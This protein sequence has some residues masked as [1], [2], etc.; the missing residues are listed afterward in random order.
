MYILHAFVY[1]Y[2]IMSK[3]SFHFLLEHERILVSPYVKSILEVLQVAID[4]LPSSSL[5]FAM[6]LHFLNW[7]WFCKRVKVFFQHC[8]FLWLLKH[9][10]PI[11]SS[12]LHFCYMAGCFTFHIYYSYHAIILRLLCR[13][14]FMKCYQISNGL[15]VIWKTII[16]RNLLT[17]D[18][19]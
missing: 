11:S 15:N 3:L 4:W 7:G 5:W 9:F 2:L 18:I 1:D 19:Y 6:Y 14:F 16:R 13:I 17:L 12:T 8:V 10:L